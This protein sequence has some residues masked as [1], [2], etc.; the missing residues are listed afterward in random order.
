[1]AHFTQLDDSAMQ[2][3]SA[4]FALGALQRWK[5][6]AAGTINSNYQLQTSEGTFFLRVNEGKSEAEVALEVS[7]LTHIVAAGVPSPLPRQCDTG[8]RFARYQGKFISVFD[9]VP[10]T[11]VDATTICDSHCNAAGQ[12]LAALHAAGQSMDLAQVG[13]GRYSYPK[14]KELFAGLSDSKDPAL[15]S[16]LPILRDE[17]A[18]LDGQ[19]E[20]RGAVPRLLI[21][22]DLFPDNVLLEGAKVVAL[23]DFEQAC[24]GSLVYDL[25]VAIN[26]WCFAEDL[27]PSRVAALLAGYQEQA[28]LGEDEIAALVVELR[29]AALRFTITRI[30]DVYLP[31]L[32][33]G[34]LPL[35][36]DFRRFQMRLTTWQGLGADG[37]RR[38]ADLAKVVASP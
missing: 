14:V 26:A 38:I 20:I 4:A 34:S 21:H 9:W 1:V 10:G 19:E 23:L 37:L 6:I 15:A 2:S 25:A 29:A 11:H 30:T 36:K 33:E 5:S 8:E 13:S 27:V 22:A 32:A 28:P 24:V 18:W 12:A 16:V 35:G 17:F 3:L 7:V 31:S